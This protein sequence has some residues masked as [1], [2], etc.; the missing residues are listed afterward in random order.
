[1]T[2]ATAISVAPAGI[3]MG[4]AAACLMGRNVAYSMA[5]MAPERGM[6]DWDVR[7]FATHC[8]RAGKAFTVQD[9]GDGRTDAQ[10]EPVEL[11]PRRCNLLC[12]LSSVFAWL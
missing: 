12:W 1:M 8:K 10:N 11:A 3:P 7:F 4:K 9:G 5:D 2:R 6:S